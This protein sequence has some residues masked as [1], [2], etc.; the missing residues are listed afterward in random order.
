MEDTGGQVRRDG[1]SEK[2]D[3]HGLPFAV[4]Y[5]YTLITSYLP[6]VSTWL[7]G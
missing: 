4:I 2:S 7:D 3:W 6:D 1:L 5:T